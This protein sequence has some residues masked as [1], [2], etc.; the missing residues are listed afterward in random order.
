MCELIFS[1]FVHIEPARST[2]S[3]PSFV[4]VVSSHEWE[5]PLFYAYLT[6]KLRAD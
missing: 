1:E 4:E 6:T 5:R 3:N 2:A